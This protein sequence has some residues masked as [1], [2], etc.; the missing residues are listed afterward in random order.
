MK[1][2][3]QTWFAEGFIDFELKKYTLLAYI[4]EIHKHFDEQKL[5]PQLADIILHYNNLLAFKQNKISLQKQFPKR[6]TKVDMDR[7]QFLYE[8]IVEDDEMMRELEEIILYALQTMDKTIRNGTEIYEF[9]EDKLCIT[10][11]GLIPL[12]INEGYFF[13]CGG[14]NRDTRVYQ[15]RLSIFEKHDEKYRSIRTEFISQWQR[16]MINTYENIKCELIR[17]KSELPNPAVYSIETDLTFPLE[18][19]LLPIAKRTLVK[20]ITLNAA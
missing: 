20:Y 7:L 12:D 8:R 18:E 14:T 10:P 1:M 19:T 5:Y 11:I 13:L 4:Q 9:V 17:Y 16:N 3:S 6:L 2:L 15:Y